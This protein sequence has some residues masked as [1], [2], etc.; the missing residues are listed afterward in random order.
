[1]HRKGCDKSDQDRS[2]RSSCPSSQAMLSRSLS[3]ARTAQP[4]TSGSKIGPQQQN[5]PPTATQASRLQKTPQKTL[6]TTVSHSF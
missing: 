4:D 3:A 5:Y 6:L 2:L 1:M